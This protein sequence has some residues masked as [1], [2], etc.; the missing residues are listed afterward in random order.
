M[1]LQVVTAP[2]EEPVTLDEA[3]ASSATGYA[4][5]TDAQLSAMITSAR[6]RLE[7]YLDRAVAEQTLALHRSC[8]PYGGG[9]ALTWAAPLQEVE[10]FSYRPYGGGAAIEIEEDVDYIL[11]PYAEPAVVY[12]M[13]GGWWP[14]TA[15]HPL[16]ITVTYVAGWEPADVPEPLKGA[17]L[18]ELAAVAANATGSSGDLRSMSIDG[19]GTLQYQTTAASGGEAML[20]PSTRV[21]VDSYRIVGA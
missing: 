8:F 11:D 12:P 10:S 15:A 2:T 9:I 1:S 3:R 18:G 20:Q 5:L 6:I 13:S 14:T 16:A 21:L 19:L 7:R 4:D 17:I